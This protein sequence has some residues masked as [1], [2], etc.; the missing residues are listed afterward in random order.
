MWA[1][2]RASR[3]FAIFS[4][5][6]GY[7]PAIGAGVQWRGSSPSGRLGKIRTR[8]LPPLQRTRRLLCGKR[9]P[10][11]T[12]SRWAL[13]TRAPA[14]NKACMTRAGNRRSSG[15]GSVYNGGTETRLQHS[16]KTQEGRPTSKVHGIRHLSG[17]PISQHFQRT[18]QESTPPFPVVVFH[19][20]ICNCA[21]GQAFSFLRIHRVPARLF[22][23]AS[24]TDGNGSLTW[25]E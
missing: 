14:R 2:E 25:R 7:I 16:E 3:F 11:F 5:R 24:V 19:A 1:P 22:A 8:V 12:G 4:L 15:V 21:A 6:L 13:D 9:M 20:R 10:S 17:H 18:R 23:A